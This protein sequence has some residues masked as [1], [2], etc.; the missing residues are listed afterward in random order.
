MTGVQTC[1][2]PIYLDLLGCHVLVGQETAWQ[3][4]P[5]TSIV[6]A[7]NEFGMGI[8]IV[9]EL[10]AL[11]LN[12]QMALNPLLDKQECVVLT[13]NNNEVVKVH[14]DAHLLVIA[15]MNP[16][17]LGVND[18]Q[19]SVRDRSNI[20]LTIDYPSIQKE[21]EI[22]AKITGVPLESCLRYAEVINECRLLKT[23]DH[24]ISKAPSTRGLIDWI[25][26]SARMGIETA[27]ELAI[28]NKYGTTPEECAAIQMVARG[29]AVYTIRL[30]PKPSSKTAS[31]PEP[32]KKV[33]VKD[34]V[35]YTVKPTPESKGSPSTK[36]APKKPRT[37]KSAKPARAMVE[38]KPAA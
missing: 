38:R 28:V 26:Y 31:M 34:P 8:L 30:H 11:T 13:L 29:K 5:L 16:D 19:D 33:R 15:S 24:K 25:R 18:L 35:K 23:V 27:F 4:G 21:A 1:A 20:I 7:A 2:L 22:V 3:D 9:N 6:R 36:R 17:I 14:H 10:N 12:A 37:A 32:T